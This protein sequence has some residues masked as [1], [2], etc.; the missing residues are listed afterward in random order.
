MRFR[1]CLLLLALTCSL[2][3]QDGGQLFT[4]Y[5]AACHGTNGEGALNGQFPPLADSPWPTGNPDRAIK[6]VLGGV[7]GELEVNGRT[8]NLEMPPQGAMLNDEQV[9]AIL[10]HVRSS[11]GNSA[12]AVDAARV[13]AVRA[14]TADRAGAWTSGELLKAHPLELKPPVRDLI[15]YVYDG[16]WKN[17]PDFSTLKPVATEEEHKGLI[18]LAKSGHKDHYGMVWEGLLDLP[19]DGSYEFHFDADDGGRLKLDDRTLAEVGG[20][21]PIGS[22]AKETPP[23]TFAKGPHR[24][25]VEFY[26]FQG[27]EEIRVGWRKAGDKNWNWLSDHKAPKSKWPEIPVDPVAGRAAIYRNFIAGTTSRAIGFGLPGGINFA[28]SAD[29]L[30]PELLWQGEFMD[31]GRHWTERGQGDQAPAGDH[32]VKLSGG[33]AFDGDTR[34]RGYKLDATGNPTFSIEVGGRRL[35]DAYRAGTFQGKPALI[36]TLTLSDGA[37]TKLLLA[38]KLPVKPA[39]G[40]DFALGDQLLVH[41]ER[42]VP[43]T[44]DG[45]TSVKL[46]PG[47]PAT[48]TYHWR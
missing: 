24:L 5:C 44:R 1:F 36:R 23:S 32:V 42:A 20:I 40:G 33:M 4:I 45:R 38:D 43:E 39:D 14:A 11:W 31:G 27:N 18:S 35:L 16:T 28:W 2:R 34:F 30:A 26:E 7:H 22:R 21:G 15:S 47:Q 29:H 10:T 48:L 6:I 3:A 41:I 37:P 9:A 8:W 13:K 12:P 25:R 17:P 46:D 19:A